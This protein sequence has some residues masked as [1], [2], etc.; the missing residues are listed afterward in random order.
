MEQ[1]LYTPGSSNSRAV[2]ARERDSADSSRP[3]ENF[4]ISKAVR[5]ELLPFSVDASRITPV[6]DFIHCVSDWI[7]ARK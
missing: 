4:C 1:S 7:R 6:S 5:Q 2:R 3:F